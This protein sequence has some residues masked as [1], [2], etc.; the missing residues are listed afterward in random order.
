MIVETRLFDEHWWGKAEPVYVTAI[1]RFG[2]FR[3]NLPAWNPGGR[4]GRVR[5]IRFSNILCRGENG[6]FIAGDG[7][8]EIENVV[9]DQVSIEIDKRTKW[10]G[11]R[12]DRRP[13]DSIGPAFR[14]PRQDPGL[15]EHPTSGIFIEHA[16]DI[17]V[18]DCE[19]R[20][21]KNRPAYFHHALEAS[22]VSGLK[23]DN[24][25][26][27]SADPALYPALAIA[28]SAPKGEGV[29]S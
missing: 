13:C 11:G 29:V 6:V 24:F 27:G 22:H 7:A 26:G 10:P 25:V 20:W 1:P 16:R 4:L 18:R 12:Q 8:S 5:N 17:R 9:L 23:L 19:V 15:R 3:E 28:E 21:G 2:G 14:D